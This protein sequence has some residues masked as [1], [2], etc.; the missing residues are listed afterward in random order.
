MPELD[1]YFDYSPITERPRLVWPGGAD[2][3]VWIAVN[4]EYYDFVPPHNPYRTYFRRT[5]APDVLLYSY[6]DYGNRVGF[7]RMLE[8]FDAYDLPGTASVSV[9]VLDHFPEIAEAMLSRDWAFMS[10]GTYN[11]RFLFGMSPVEERAYIQDNIDAVMRATGKPLKG[12]FGPCASLT[13]NTMSLIAEAGLIYSCDWYVDDQPFPLHVPQGQLISL[14]YAWDL[15]D[16]LL[17]GYLAGKY[18][19]DDFVDMCVEQFDVLRAEAIGTGRVMCIALHPMC[20]GQ[21][22]RAQPLNRLFEHLRSATDVWYA[23]ADEIADYYMAHYYDEAVEV[24]SRGA[25]S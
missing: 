23:T 5:P 14:P 21:A 3:A 4:V 10:H 18:E 15:N 24:A 7:W 25:K 8:A 9:A 16:G 13:P 19:A 6:C 11:T 17:V 1:D 2:L 12:M 22:H 20:F